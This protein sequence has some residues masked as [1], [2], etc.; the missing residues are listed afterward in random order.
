MNYIIITGASKGLGE[1]IALELLHESHHLICISRSKSE[2]LEKLAAAKNC[3]ITFISFD[4]A[5]THDVPDLASLIFEYIPLERASGVYLINNAGVINPVGRTEDCPADEVEQH[6]RINLISPML[7]T[8]AF[9][10]YT[11]GW[12][13]EKRIIN[14]SS[15][16]AKNPYH[17]WSSYCTG[18]AGID[19]FTQCVGTEQQDL[20]FPAEIMAVAPGIIDT[21]MQTTIR[22]T[23]EEQFIHRQKFVELKESG[24]LVPPQVAGKRLAKLLFSDEFSNGGII[25][26]RDTY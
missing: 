7:L 17:G 19:M 26:I 10:K 18:K 5:M 11:N 8:A 23:T 12:K 22:G 14:I 20:D 15:G 9:I 21:E 13:M 16:A 6:M 2:K 1:G 3:P 4:F 24:Q 25:D